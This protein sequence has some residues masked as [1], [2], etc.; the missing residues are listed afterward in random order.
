MSNLQVRNCCLK[1]SQAKVMPQGVFALPAN[2]FCLQLFFA[3]NLTTFPRL[4]F[5]KYFTCYSLQPAVPKTVEKSFL[6][7]CS[8]FNPRRLKFY[9]TTMVLSFQFQF[10]SLVVSGYLKLIWQNPCSLQV[11]PKNNRKQHSNSDDIFNNC[12][13]SC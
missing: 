4:D 1:L 11:F 7:I 10:L 9:S 6:A 2:I 8:N 3:V 13:V 12:C 5:N